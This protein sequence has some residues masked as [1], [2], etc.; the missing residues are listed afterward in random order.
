MIAAEAGVH[1][2]MLG[3]NPYNPSA[4]AVGPVTINASNDPTSEYT[5]STPQVP[6]QGPA[7]IPLSGYAIGGGENW[8]SMRFVASVTG[9]NTRYN[10][11]VQV[12]SGVGY[13]PVELTT[14]YR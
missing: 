4:S 5:I 6:Q 12:D 13:G 14:V 11:N 9:T 8:G 7:K 2:L 3:F 1:D 10:S